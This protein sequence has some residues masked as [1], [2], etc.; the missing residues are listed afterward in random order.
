MT[1]DEKTARR[2]RDLLMALDRFADQE[3]KMG[4][5][6]HTSNPKDVSAEAI[7]KLRKQLFGEREVI[8]RFVERNPA[9]LGREDLELVGS[10]REAVRGEMFLVKS[11]KSGAILNYKETFY[12]VLGL[13]QPLEEVVGM[14][15]PL[16]VEALLL[17][18]G[19]QI[20]SDGLISSYPIHL[21][22]GIRKNLNESYARARRQGLV[23][24]SLL[25]QPV[26][27]PVARVEANPHRETVREMAAR[28]D[29]LRGGATHPLHT[30]AL[31]MLRW[32]TALAASCLEEHPDPQEIR[33]QLSQI[34]KAFKQVDQIL[35]EG[36]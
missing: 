15:P 11:L 12:Q 23:R 20:I 28:A 3:L 27:V 14:R 32:G 29:R 31:A 25:S 6:L 24:T 1:V 8:D 13:Y 5:G 2:I 26:P 36:I 17:P 33:K 16:L 10:W 34:T 7:F 30:P 21:G 4:L 22:G 9:R 19:E 35:W 18:L